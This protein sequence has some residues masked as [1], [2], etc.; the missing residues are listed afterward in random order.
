MKAIRTT[1]FCALVLAGAG[2]FAHGNGPTDPQIAAIVVVANQVDVD[3]GKLAQE[4]SGTKDVK[5]F[6]ALM[7]ADHTAVNR[8]AGELVQKLKVTPEANATSDSLQQGGDKNLATLR[9]LSG[10]AFDK[11]YVDHE[12]AY[13]EAVI[14]ALDKTLIPSA[15]NAELKALLIKVRP[16]FIA[17]LEHARQLQ[18]RL[19]GG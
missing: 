6:A 3:A 14:E 4:K 10:A 1:W 18:K 11:A 13:H 15:R 5:E 2:A 12:V 19:A 7:V 9:G 8:A 17:H 16:A